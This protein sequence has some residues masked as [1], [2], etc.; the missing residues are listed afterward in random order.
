MPKLDAETA[1][2]QLLAAAQ[3]SPSDE[4]TAV[5]IKDYPQLRKGADALYLDALENLEPAAKFNPLDYYPA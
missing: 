2:T 4:E 3:L 5:M 1:V